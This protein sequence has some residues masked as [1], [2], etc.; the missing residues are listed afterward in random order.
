[1]DITGRA[2][3]WIASVA[4][5][6]DGGLG[7]TEDGVLS[8]DL[9]SGTAGGLFGCAE[10]EAAG[11]GTAHVSAGARGRSPGA[12]PRLRPTRCGTPT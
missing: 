6:A 8:D 11:P 9:Y 10:A 5:G 12:S 3:D 7:W 1:V 4:V 2:F